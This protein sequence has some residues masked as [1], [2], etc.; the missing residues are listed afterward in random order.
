MATKG[1]KEKDGD[2]S[3]PLPVQLLT[4]RLSQLSPKAHSYWK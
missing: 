2:Q 3:Q 4:L 1:Q